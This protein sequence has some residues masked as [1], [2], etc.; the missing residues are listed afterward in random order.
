MEQITSVRAAIAALGGVTKAAA[1]LGLKSA[2]VAGNWQVRDNIPPE[3]FLTV[4]DALKARGKAVT[5]DLFGM[6]QSTKR[7]ENE[8]G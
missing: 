2:A 7:Q 5:P 8:M 3:Y 4:T 6:Y 1:L